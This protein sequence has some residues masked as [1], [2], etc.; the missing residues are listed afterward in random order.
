MLIVVILGFFCLFFF[1]GGRIFLLW[2]LCVFSF[3]LLIVT[4]D[5]N[6]T[7]YKHYSCA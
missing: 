5:F 4:V 7:I 3:V 6:D 1:F 2:S